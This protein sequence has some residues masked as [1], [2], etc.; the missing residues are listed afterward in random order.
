MQNSCPLTC[1]IG[2][3]RDVCARI[4]DPRP[5]HAFPETVCA[6]NIRTIES[7]TNNTLVTDIMTDETWK[8]L[9]EAQSEIQ[10]SIGLTDRDSAYM[11]NISVIFFSYCFFIII[12]NGNPR[13]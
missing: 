9:L 3:K 7:F 5:R 11:E 1:K 10:A 12:C 13:Q 6:I 4:S 2:L 8:E